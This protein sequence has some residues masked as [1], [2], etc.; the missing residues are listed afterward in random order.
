LGWNPGFE[1]L[2]WDPTNFDKPYH[3]Q[4]NFTL[5]QE[6][7]AGYVNEDMHREDVRRDILITMNEFSLLPEPDLAM[8]TGDAISKDF[9]EHSESALLGRMGNVPHIR[10]DDRTVIAAVTQ[11]FKI[12][13]EVFFLQIIA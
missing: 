11:L 7:L 9:V 8:Q 2:I 6:V 13:A 3:R 5:G 10:F 4:A 1:P 12:R